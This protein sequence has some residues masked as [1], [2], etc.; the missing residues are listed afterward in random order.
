MVSDDEMEAGSEGN[1]A[2]RLVPPLGHP[3]PPAL[4]RGHYLQQC[5]NFKDPGL[6]SYGGQH[7]TALRAVAEKLFCQLPPP[8][9]TH[10][11]LYSGSNVSIHMESYCDIRGVCFDGDA[12]V[13]MF[14]SA[15]KRVRDI[16]AGDRLVGGARAVCGSNPGPAGQHMVR[17][18]EMWVTPYHPVRVGGEWVFPATLAPP[19]RVAVPYTY[20]F[21]LDSGHVAC[22]GGVECVTLGHGTLLVSLH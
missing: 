7:F 12:P 13:A 9:P 18:G 16:V 8:V 2:R 3:L 10:A 17:L 6:Q 22:V 20:D 21:V 5:L 1:V 19:Q 11:H 14:D 4:A 15:T